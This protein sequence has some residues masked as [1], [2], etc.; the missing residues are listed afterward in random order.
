[1]QRCCDAFCGAH[2]ICDESF[3]NEG[4]MNLEKED[5]KARRDRYSVANKIFPLKL[6]EISHRLSLLVRWTVGYLARNHYKILDI[7]FLKGAQRRRR[8]NSAR[9]G[10]VE[11]ASPK[12]T[13]KGKKSKR[14]SNSDL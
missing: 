10:S 2:F 11:K 14:K 12:S 1:M 8:T 4:L 3:T 13:T 7:Q 6:K 9:A 5:L